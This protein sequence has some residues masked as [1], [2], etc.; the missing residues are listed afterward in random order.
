[1]INPCWTRP[2]STVDSTEV[3]NSEHFR[4]RVSWRCS[5]AHA[6]PGV[7]PW[8]PIGRGCKVVSSDGPCAPLLRWLK[9]TGRPNLFQIGRPTRASSWSAHSV[10]ARSRSPTL[11]LAQ[12]CD[13]ARGVWR[14]R[15][16][17]GL[18]LRC[19]S[20]GAPLALE[21]RPRRAI[22]SPLRLRIARGGDAGA[23]PSVFQISNDWDLEVGH[24]GTAGAPRHPRRHTATFLH[25][26]ARDTGLGWPGRAL[27]R[28]RTDFGTGLDCPELGTSVLPLYFALTVTDRCGPT[29][30]WKL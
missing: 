3:P 26:P 27:Q 16:H 9:M 17:A 2:T 1:M 13:R 7:A 30:G 14:P 24:Q 8:V 18:Q 22:A 23:G 5:G 21:P 20:S 15:A 25:I 28:P 29:V 12:V 6:R 19:T 10:P 4:F 11:V